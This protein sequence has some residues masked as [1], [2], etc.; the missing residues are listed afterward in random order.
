[1]Q[2]VI[3]EYLDRKSKKIYTVVKRTKEILHKPLA[4]KTEVYKGSFDYI[5]TCGIDLQPQD[6]DLKTFELIQIDGFIHKV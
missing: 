2:E 1:M 5:T 4:S 6:E 3:G